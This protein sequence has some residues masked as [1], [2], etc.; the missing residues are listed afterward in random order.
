METEIFG[1]VILKKG[2]V[3]LISILVLTTLLMSACAPSS[4][5]PA[6]ASSPAASSKPAAATASAPA[7][8]AAATAAPPSASVPATSAAGQPQKGGVLRYGLNQEYPTI[9]YPTTQQYSSGP[10]VLDIALES[11]LNLDSKGNV[12]P[13][14]ATSWKSDD[15]APSLTLTLR[16]GVKFH[17]GTDFN[18]AAAKWN[19][20]QVIT[21]KKAE[22]ASV[23][24]VDVVDNNTIRL[25]LS[26]PDGLLL[27]YLA[28][29]RSMMLSPTSFQSSAST[30][31][32]RIAWAENNPVGTGPF[33]LVSRQRDVK[34]V[35]K[36]FD[37]YWQP[38]KP[39]LDEID[40]I[41]FADETTE[42]AAFKKGDLDVALIQQPQNIKMLD[43]EGKYNILKGDLNYCSALEGDSK[44]PDSP[45]AKIQVRQAAAYSVDNAQFAKT[46]GYGNWVPTNQYG[47]TGQVGYNPDVVGYP[48][49]PAKAKELLAAAGYPNGFKT[50]L[51][52]TAQDDAALSSLQAYFKEVGI[53]ADVQIV[54]M[55]KRVDMF[56]SSGW[57]GVWWWV[58]A[59]QPSILINMGRNFTAAN[60]PT[61]MSSV[62]IPK[63]F[64]DMVTKAITTTDPDLQNKLTMQLQ[65]DM[66]D[67]YAFL[68]FL[69]GQYS[70]IPMTKKVHDFAKDTTLH[71]NP[72]NIWM[73]K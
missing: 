27:T 72:G 5:T 53:N 44:H 14:L 47:I 45:W 62:D 10:L 69:V 4:P 57:Q 36:R 37:G 51:Y 23:K 63:D 52:G 34:T 25:N 32:E 59:P 54:T 68:T 41:N 8:T 17:D 58:A 33:K 21:A 30:D 20:D 49:N 22:V 50:N 64:S 7:P 19:L 35:F 42:M 9:G 73:D 16:Q 46:L 12:I 61:R 2:I 31:K 43:S 66:T 70:P 71:W 13:W 6:P 29:V 15:S 3:L 67:K 28:V 39:Y 26:Q 11:L 56:S 65:K 18:A 24:S 38:G 40:F 48:Y 55:A 1:G 60:S